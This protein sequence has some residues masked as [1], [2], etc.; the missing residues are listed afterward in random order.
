MPNSRDKNRA[1]GISSWE[2]GKKKMLFP[3]RCT[4]ARASAALARAVGADTAASKRS[5][6]TPK[7]VA[8]ACNQAVVPSTPSGNGADK[9]TA[10]RACRARAVSAKKG[11]ASNSRVWRPTGAWSD[12]RRG[13]KKRTRSMPMLLNRRMN[14]SSTTSARV[15]TTS[16]SCGARAACSGSPGTIDDKQA[17]SPCVNVVSI[18]LPE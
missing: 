1:N 4:F 3:S 6:G 11:C 2:S 5:P 12:A 16:S 17:S 13:G 10:P 9:S 18:P 7:A 15:P 8:A 14:W